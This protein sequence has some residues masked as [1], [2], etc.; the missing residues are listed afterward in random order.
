MEIDKAQLLDM[1]SRLPRVERM[2]KLRA[3]YKLTQAAVAEI[4]GVTRTTVSNWEDEKG[5]GHQPGKIARHRMATYYGLP[6]Y[7]FTDDWGQPEVRRQKQ[8]RRGAPKEPVRVEG[9]TTITL[10][11]PDPL[12]QSPLVKRLG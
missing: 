6:T 8:P 12:P 4:A 3:L 7:V 10:P 1:L 2:V 9:T 5:N 11:D